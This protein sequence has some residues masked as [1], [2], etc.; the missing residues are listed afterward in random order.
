MERQTV[1]YM[2]G[3]TKCQGFLVRNEIVKEA[4]PGILVIPA[5]YG[6]D[7]FAKKRAEELARLGYVAFVADIYGNGKKAKDDAEAS[8]LMSPLF[9]DRAQLRMRAIA[10]YNALREESS[11]NAKKIGAIGFCFGGLTVIELVRSGADVLASCSF[12]ALL[13]DTLGEMKA[14]TAAHGGKIKGSLLILHGHDD[15]MVS[16]ADVAAIQK[17]MTEAGVDWQMHT[18]GLTMHAFTVPEAKNPDRGTVYNEK[19]AKRSWQAMQQF[20]NECFNKG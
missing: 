19:A 14:T 18:Y 4:R 3:N 20:F 8:S 17:E 2:C 11:V 16:E 15:P 6:I 1:D 10:A 9:V 12:H 7:D 5:W 13:G